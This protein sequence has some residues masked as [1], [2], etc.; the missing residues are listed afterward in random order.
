M[1]IDHVGLLPIYLAAATA[2]LVLVADLLGP[3]GVAVATR[4]GAVAPSPLRVGFTAGTAIVG[5]LATLLASVVVH[6]DSDEPRVA[7]CAGQVGFGEGITPAQCSWT[8]DD[9]A[10]LVAGLVAALVIVVLLLS[11]PLLRSGA[12]PVGEF[13]FLLACSLAGGVALG[14]ARD[15]I[16]LIIALETLTL[17]IYILVGMRR[18]DRAAAEGAVTFLLTSVVATAIALLG[19]ALLYASTGAVHLDELVSA[20]ALDGQLRP[21]AGAG[22]LLLL[23]GLAFKVA[24]VPAHAWAPTTYD[25]APVPIALYLSTASKLG[26]IVAI[27]YVVAGAGEEWWHVTGPA[28]AVLAAGTLLVGSLVALRQQRMTRLVAWSSVAQTGFI[29]APL[30]G[31]AVSQPD[32][33]GSTV[34]YTLVYLVVE[35]AAFAG[36]VAL[37][38]RGA[39]G[40]TLDDYTGLGRTAPLRAGAFAF[41]LIGLAGLPPALAGLFAKV[42]VVRSLVGA[43]IW[44]LAVVVALASVIGLAVYLRP[45]VAL[46]RPA[47][48]PRGRGSLVVGGVLAVATV[49]AVVIGFAPDV[50]LRVGE[51]VAGIAYR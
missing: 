39:D 37:R 28:L 19:A 5:S 2:I 48:A 4:D 42:F 49:V 46:Y 14:G 13:C 18:A 41:A 35:V 12:A 27:I 26:G 10:A 6:L 43:G 17:P 33:V 36:I 44:W 22:L 38:P 45:L 7:F 1:K 9:A 29:L 25:G 20:L 31:L 50:L 30:A 24:A 47:P 23:G 32:A 11:L 16:T 3:Q 21:V 34:A 8:F 40:G 51:Q 15:L